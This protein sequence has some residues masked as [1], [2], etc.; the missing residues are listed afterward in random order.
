MKIFLILLLISIIP[1]MIY[2][3]TETDTIEINLQLTEYKYISSK[4][5]N[6]RIYQIMVESFQDGD[7]NVNYNT[8]YGPSHHCGDLKGITNSLPYIKSLGMNAIWL[9]PIFD[10]E[11]GTPSYNPDK[12]PN[13]KLDATGYFTRNYFKIDPNFGT[14]EDARE[15]ITN[16]HNLGLYVF[17]DGVFG[18]HKGN[19]PISPNGNIPKGRSSKVSY[20]ESLEF[21]KEVALY[22]IDELEIDGWRLDQAYQIPIKYLR[23][24]REAVEAKC[25]QRIY[26]GKKWGTLGYIVGEVW[27]KAEII[28]KKGYGKN[29]NPGLLSTFD[30]P[31]R[32]KLVQALACEEKGLRIPDA[33]ILVDGFLSHEI[34]HDKAIPNLMLTNH[35]LVRFG[36]LIQRAGL[37]GPNSPNY[38][39]RHK[40]AFS[41]LAAYTG[42]ITIYYGDE[43]GDEV[44]N[45]I[46]KIDDPKEKCWLKGL[47]DDHVSRTSGKITNLTKNENDL[48]NYVAQLMKMRQKNAAL[49]NGKT[50]NL[51]AENNIYV[52]LK[53][54]DDNKIL[55]TLN[56]ANKKDS[57]IIPSYIL[58]TDTLVDYF[59]H[60]TII[61]KDGFFIIHIDELSGNFFICK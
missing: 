40:A 60:K 37:A 41:F 21:Y 8:G 33:S 27:N 38:W 47:C 10:S 42:P 30:F 46:A 43:I 16:A 56:I 31:L 23:E 28:S 55:Y 51:I 58:E 11:K 59:S 15:M 48:K 12:N 13:K 26:Q 34:Y 19:I 2:G 5:N 54:K 53:E 36:D 29:D 4:F 7:P 22:W 50:T 1:I 17:L 18:H 14:L 49:W 24:I 20:P 35:D 39:K 9:T 44:E 3:Y 25:S 32:Y 45:F 61:S 52:D 57:I 6:L